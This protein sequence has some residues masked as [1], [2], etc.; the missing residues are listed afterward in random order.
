MGIDRA[1]LEATMANLAAQDRDARQMLDRIEGARL[2][3]EAMLAKVRE[4]EAKA[5][6]ASEGGGD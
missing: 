6:D 3:C 4:D 2:L 5:A 1:Y